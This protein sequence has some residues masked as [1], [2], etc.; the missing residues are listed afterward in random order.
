MPTDTPRANIRRFDVFAE[1][2]RL[3]ARERKHMNASDAKAYGFAVAKVVAARKLGGYEPGLIR[4][5]KKRARAGHTEREASGEA[6]WEHFGSEREF[7]RRI[8]ERMGEG[9]YER[10]FQPAVR[11]A[12]DAGKEYEEVRDTLRKEWNEALLRGW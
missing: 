7:D 4:E 6:W 8:I 5:W 11:E 2:S 1:W 3:T 12:L 10:V 9:F